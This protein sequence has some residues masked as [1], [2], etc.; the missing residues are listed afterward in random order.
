MTRRIGR[1]SMLGCALVATTVFAATAERPRVVVMGVTT[2][3]EKLKALAD[4]ISEQLL[5]ELGKTEKVEVMGS[6][7]VA[8]VL[9]MER[10]RATMGCADDTSSCVAEISAALGAPWLVT[11]SIGQSGKTTRLDLKLIRAR[12]GKVV[13][14]DGRNIKDESEVYDIVSDVV[15]LLVKKIDLAAAASGTGTAG[16]PGL[17]VEQPAAGPSRAGPWVTIGV[18][19]AALVTGGIFVGLGSSLRSSTQESLKGQPA[20]VTDTSVPD[21]ATA[22]G[23]LETAS[24]QMLMGAI[25]G[26]AGLLAAAGG[27]TW[28]MLGASEPAKSSQLRVLVGPSALMVQGEF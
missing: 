15:S 14:R 3:G 17:V 12:D 1:M 16:V 11:G 20:S 10:Q 25:I 23:A 22:R 9:G 8:A 19:A 28:L 7:D 27:V 2:S 6:S 5:T 24:S 13:F 26:G 4:S 18:G 21:Y